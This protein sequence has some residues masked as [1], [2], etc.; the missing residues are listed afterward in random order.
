[1]AYLQCP[2]LPILPR[3]RKL[4]QKSFSWLAFGWTVR[5]QR[6]RRLLQGDSTGRVS[7]FLFRP[8]LPLTKEV[9]CSLMTSSS[10]VSSLWTKMDKNVAI[11][12]ERKYRNILTLLKPIWKKSCICFKNVHLVIWRSSVIVPLYSFTVP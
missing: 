12:F 1:M 2:E 5:K 4:N 11:M 10:K 7:T 9:E 3:L 8:L 6:V